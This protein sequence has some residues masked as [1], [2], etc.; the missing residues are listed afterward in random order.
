MRI[1]N[2]IPSGLT[3]YSAVNDFQHALHDQVASGQ[4]EDTLIGAEFAPAWTAG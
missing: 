2:L 4:A 1:L 3:D